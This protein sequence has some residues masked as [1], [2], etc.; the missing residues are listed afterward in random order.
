MLFHRY[1]MT[2]GEWQLA[3]VRD[4]LDY[5]LRGERMRRGGVAMTLGGVVLGIAGIVVSGVAGLEGLEIRR[6]IN[7]APDQMSEFL[8]LA[9]NDV[10]AQQLQRTGA[11]FAVRGAGATVAGIH[12]RFWEESERRTTA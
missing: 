2:K 9:P 10:R 7:E 8:T 12:L 4:L 5:R 11:I 6:K 3:D 1:D